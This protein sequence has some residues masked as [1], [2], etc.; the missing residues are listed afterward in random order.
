MDITYFTDILFDLINESDALNITDIE[1]DDENHFL[2]VF[3]PD[4][5]VFCVVCRQVNGT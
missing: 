2:R 1:S 3:M 5:N 4:G